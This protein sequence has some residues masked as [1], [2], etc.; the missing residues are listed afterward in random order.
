MFW[1]F[2][3]P[4]PVRSSAVKW[5]GCPLDA[6][7]DTQSDAADDDWCDLSHIYTLYDGYDEC[8]D[9]TDTTA[10]CAP[11]E[12]AEED[13]PNDH[14]QDEDIDPVD[15]LPLYW[16]YDECISVKALRLPRKTIWKKPSHCP[17]TDGA[18]RRRRQRQQQ[19]RKA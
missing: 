19:R 13:D 6:S 10:S 15:D 7:S 4:A 2:C 8:I 5:S 18:Q 12:Q 9:W 3:A 14:V 1:K 16:G 11:V 17:R